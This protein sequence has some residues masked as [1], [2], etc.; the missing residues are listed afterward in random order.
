MSKITPIKKNSF[1]FQGRMLEFEKILVNYHLSIANFSSE[2]TKVALIRAYL[3]IHGE[4]TQRQLKDLTKFSISTISTNLANLVDVG[5]I[6]RKMK[7]GTHEYIYSPAP[8]SRDSVDQAL[9]SVKP[10]I[11]FLKVV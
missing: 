6:K 5:Y 7:T 10:E 9:G 2:S 8:A 11:N 1:V 4:L 3:S